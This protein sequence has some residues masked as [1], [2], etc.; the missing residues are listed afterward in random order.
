MHDDERDHSS[1]NN[2][3]RL[4]RKLS[5]WR[6]VRGKRAR[7]RERNKKKAK[8]NEPR[9]SVVVVVVESAAQSSMN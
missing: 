9:A 7:E 5:I 4:T 3:N 6:T 8:K 1:Y 2:N